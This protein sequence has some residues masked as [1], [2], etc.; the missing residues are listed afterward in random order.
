MKITEV[1]RYRLYET[2]S[3]CRYQLQDAL[4]I[5]V[6][7]DDGYWLAAPSNP[8]TG[9]DRYGTG[10]SIK[11]AIRELIEIMDADYRADLKHV[12]AK[13]GNKGSCNYEIYKRMFY[14]K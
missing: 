6:V 9:S 14:K 11:K 8:A 1:R 12:K 3:T 4:D 2:P 7:W 5:D 10:D 13:K